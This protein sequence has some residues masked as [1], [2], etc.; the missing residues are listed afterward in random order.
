[1]RQIQTNL[2]SLTIGLGLVLA[3][4]LTFSN[5]AKAG[6][7]SNHGGKI[8]R[9]R[10]Y[11]STDNIV[12]WTDPPLPSHANCTDLAFFVLD[13]S[14]STPDR[15]D[16]ML[17]QLLTA[18]ATGADVVVGYDDVN[19]LGARVGLEIIETK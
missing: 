18:K 6:W 19:C 8:V 14:T 10:T 16:R 5:A 15:V 9:V 17:S 13:A 4:L 11:N 12:V 1:M 7:T 2:H 3:A